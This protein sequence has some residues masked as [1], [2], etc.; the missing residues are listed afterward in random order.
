MFR[1]WAETRMYRKTMRLAVGELRRAARTANALAKLHALDNAE[2][3]LK[4]QEFAQLCD[5]QV[6]PI[7]QSFFEKAKSFFR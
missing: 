1:R 5:E 3:K 2:Q 7:A 6:N 4:L